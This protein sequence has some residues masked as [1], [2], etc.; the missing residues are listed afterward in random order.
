MTI[1]N[2][3]PNSWQGNTDTAQPE[4]IQ[5]KRYDSSTF[6]DYD[7][8]AEDKF[9]KT[10]QPSQAVKMSKHSE[11]YD[12]AKYV[13]CE[14]IMERNEVSSIIE[15]AANRNYTDLESPEGFITFDFESDPLGRGIMYECDKKGK[16]LRETT[17]VEETGE[18]YKIK[19]SDGMIFDF[20][21]D[22]AAP[23]K[24]VWAKGVIPRNN[25]RNILIDVNG[26]DEPNCLETDNNCSN[27]DQ[28]RIVIYSNGRM[29]IHEDDEKAVNYVMMDTKAH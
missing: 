1:I 14:A 22:T 20:S 21:S 17:F 9:V 12:R 26:E 23:Y 28:F 7:L 19:T 15:V 24:S 11:E 27:P 13:L 25:T 29:H 8:D 6:V 16:V 3:K 10:L 18:I 5:Q 4:R 2:F